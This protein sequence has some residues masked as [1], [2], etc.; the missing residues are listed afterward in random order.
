M[1]MRALT[2]KEGR[3]FVETDKGPWDD[4][5]MSHWSAWIGRGIKKRLLGAMIA[6]TCESV[7]QCRK[8]TRENQTIFVVIS[9][10]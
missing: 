7:D 4:M 5:S 2:R 3:I 10:H 9:W 8:I 6:F 1:K